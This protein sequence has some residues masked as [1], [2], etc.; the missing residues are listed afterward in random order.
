MPDPAARI[1]NPSVAPAS[2]W[3]GWVG[4][5]S[6]FFLLCAVLA[7]IVTL[8]EGWGEYRQSQWPATT[9]R[10]QRCQLDQSP[11][12]SETYVVID[13]R[14]AFARSGQAIESRAR[15]RSRRASRGGALQDWLESHPDGSSILARYNPDSPGQA[16][17]ITP[18]PVLWGPHT[19]ENL[20]LFALFAIA[21]VAT[22]AT[23]RIGRN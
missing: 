6:L 3:R 22:F 16:A 5:S 12:D 14:I 17:L 1:S 9:A 21:S 13:C 7:L 15:S 19:P 18:E 8:A 2:K 11:G 23:A 4:L 10:I 20:R